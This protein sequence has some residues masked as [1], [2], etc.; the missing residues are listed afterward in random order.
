MQQDI[1]YSL[2]GRGGAGQKMFDFVKRESKNI[3]G[4]QRD[5]MKIRADH[6]TSLH[7]DQ[8]LAGSRFSIPG[9]SG[10]GFCQIPGSRDFSGRDLP[11]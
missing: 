1:K 8:A 9:F 7:C 11:L 2:G 4:Y 6:A 5:L 3:T 10:T